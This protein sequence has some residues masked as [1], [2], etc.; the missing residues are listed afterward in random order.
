[1]VRMIDPGVPGTFWRFLVADDA[2]I[3]RFLMRDEESILNICERVAVDAWIESN[4][5]FHVMRDF[6]THSELV[7]AGLWGGVRG[8]LPSMHNLIKEWLKGRKTVVYNQT[9][10]DQIF[11]REKIWRII[12]H[13]VLAHDSVF[14][15]GDKVDFPSLGTLPPWKHVG[16]DDFIFFEKKK[17]ANAEPKK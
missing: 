2:Q 7:L 3:D 14:D 12:Q 16:Q 4:R 6:Y 11:L 5:H 10:I 8:A 17:P 1:M 9:T 15:F 13:S